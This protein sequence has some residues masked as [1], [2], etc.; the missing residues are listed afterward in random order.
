LGQNDGKAGFMHRERGS[1][2][3]AD[4]LILF[5]EKGHAIRGSNG[6]GKAGGAEKNKSGGGGQ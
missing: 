4:G 1:I 2:T 5:T 3:Y 6:G